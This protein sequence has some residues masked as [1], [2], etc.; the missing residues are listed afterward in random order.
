MEI[1]PVV[2]LEDHELVSLCLAL[3]PRPKTVLDGVPVPQVAN[4]PKG[5]A[6][7]RVSAN[8]RVDPK[9]RLG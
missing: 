1:L 8:G 4:N 5:W 6:T 9:H 3:T 2:Y 7:D